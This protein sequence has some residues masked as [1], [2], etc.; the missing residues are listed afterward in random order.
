MYLV[1][2]PQARE[3][4]TIDVNIKNML[5]MKNTIIRVFTPQHTDLP[6]HNLCGIA[7]YDVEGKNIPSEPH[8]VIRNIDHMN[9]A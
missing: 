1:M 8:I 3:G 5:E 7:C 9:P 4:K 2:S 6:L